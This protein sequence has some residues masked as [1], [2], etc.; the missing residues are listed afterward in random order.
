M[1]TRKVARP[2]DEESVWGRE[3]RWKADRRRGGGGVESHSTRQSQAREQETKPHNQGLVNDG[4]QGRGRKERFRW[5]HQPL[6]AL[7]AQEGGWRRLEGG[8]IAA[9]GPKCSCRSF[10]EQRTDQL[11]AFVPRLH[12]I[13]SSPAVRAAETHGLVSRESLDSSSCKRPVMSCDVMRC[14]TLRVQNSVALPRSVV[15][16]SAGAL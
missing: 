5:H 13:A 4:P 6:V 3:G 11:A 12:R 15:S 8:E 9:E 2:E 7:V 14:I 1:R 16:R 10:L